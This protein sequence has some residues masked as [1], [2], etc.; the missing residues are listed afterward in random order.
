MDIMKN[1]CDSMDSIRTFTLQRL[2]DQTAELIPA[3]IGNGYDEFNIK[4][5]Y[6]LEQ[7]L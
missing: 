4:L 6:F 3:G 2:R 1:A 7:K 5:F